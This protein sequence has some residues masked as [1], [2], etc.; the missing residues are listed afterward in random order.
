MLHSLSLRTPMNRLVVWPMLLS[1]SNEMPLVSAASP[2]MRTTFS[3]SRFCR[4]P[5]PCRGPRKA[6]CPRTRAVTIVRASLRNAKPFRPS[7]VRTVRKRRLRSISSFWTS[8]LMAHVPDEFVPRGVENAMHIDGELHHAERF[9]PRYHQLLASPAISSCGDFPA[10]LLKLRQ[11][12][13]F[14]MR[15]AVHH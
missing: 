5:Q 7:V 10:S 14:H 4:A 12:E 9:R 15:R 3:S 11:R 8:T 6:P 1:A 13:L 2:K